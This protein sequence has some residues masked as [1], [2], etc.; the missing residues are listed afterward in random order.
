MI[1]SSFSMDTCLIHLSDYIRFNLDK[2]NYVDM[3]SLDLQKDFDTVDH[4]IL[5]D[6]LKTI[7]L[8]MLSDGSI[9]IYLVGNNV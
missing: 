9:H 7:F 5:L 6:K 1:F 2:G 4:V 8:L 3:V